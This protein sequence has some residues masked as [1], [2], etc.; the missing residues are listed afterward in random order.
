MSMLPPCPPPPPAPVPVAS[1]SPHPPA[2]TLRVRTRRGVAR[3][4]PSIYRILA[5]P[6]IDRAQGPWETPGGMSETHALPEK[7]R[8]E[9]EEALSRRILIL[10]GAMGTMIQRRQLGEADFRGER[11][12][13]HPI[14]VKGD[15][16][17]LC[18][19]RPD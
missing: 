15:S 18:L 8:S 5:R 1:S 11:F 13:R 4:K 6:R 2:T 19:V 14:D 10:D 7:G 17:L 12:A 16:D 9:L 3:R